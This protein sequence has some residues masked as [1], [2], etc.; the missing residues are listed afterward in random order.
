ME[1]FV[2]ALLSRI[3]FGFA[4]VTLGF[5]TASAQF[6]MPTVPTFTVDLTGSPDSVWT[7]P[8][9]VRIDQCCGVTAPD[10]CVQFILTLDPNANSVVMDIPTGAGCGA[11][12]PG[13]LFYQVN[14]GPQIAIGTP[15]CLVGTGPH[16]ITFCKP[17]NNANCYQIRSIPAPN[18]S[19][20]A[21]SSDGC[22]ALLGTVGY[23]ATTLV[24]NSIP[25]NPLFESFLSC[26]TG[27]DTVTVTRGPGAP[28]FVDYRVCGTPLGSC[29]VA[30]VCDSFRV[31]FVSDL[32]VDIQPD[33]PAV[34]FGAPA[35]TVTANITG[36]AA[37][38]TYSWTSGG[39]P[40]GTNSPNLSVLPG[41]YEVSVNDTTNCVI[42][43]DTVVVTSFSVPIDANAGSDTSI[44]V[45]T[46][47]TLAGV[48]AGASGGIWSGGSGTFV[49]GPATL[50]AQYTPSA[51]EISAGFV[52]L[53]LVTTGNFTCP[54]DSDFVRINIIPL[55]T[56][57]IS[58]NSPVCEF[59]T[60]SYSTPA[61][62]NN[63]YTWT[64]VGGT[65]ASGQGTNSITV[66]WGAST[67]GSITL[68]EENPTGCDSTR[69]LAVTVNP[70]PNP[71]I[72]GPLSVCQFESGNYSISATA[73]SSYNWTV[74]GGT[75]ASGQ[76][77]N[78]IVVNWLAPGGGSVSVRENNSFNCDTTVAINIIINPMPQPVIAG[79]VSVCA[80][81]Q[82]AYS[83]PLDRKSVV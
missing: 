74:T 68:T 52:V 49:P 44:C 20:D 9:N 14:C 8:P 28:A 56:P 57:A 6:C 36:G 62:V 67:A 10:K 55:P 13:A 42:A 39:V 58:G 77:T 47:A 53:K 7:S 66:N 70:K 15:V 80:F 59:T 61:V 51:A 21:I 30:Q 23:N 34:C 4:L 35:T 45:G 38:Y 81:T 5:S 16:V 69:V 71:V 2:K 37:P 64:V 32:A 40:V 83:T 50:N 60:S 43:T 24:W 54:A 11:R 19:G 73:G 26:T 18:A 12:P 78:A 17:G 63:N 29:N 1:A 46:S 33:S 41:T 75:V 79:A 82:E 27:C 31:F 48:V 76:G 22:S 3:L 65:I 25:P 72:A